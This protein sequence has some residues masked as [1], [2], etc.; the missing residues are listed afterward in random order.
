MTAQAPNGRVLSDWPF[1]LESNCLASRRV[2]DP[3]H[4]GVLWCYQQGTSM[5]SPHVTGVAALII[6][7]FGPMPPGTVV[8]YI[9]QTADPQ[10]CPSAA[11]QAAL[12]ASFPS[13]DTGGPQVCQG[14]S[15][16][17]SWYGDGQVNALSAVTHS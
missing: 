1:A 8:A 12:S 13:L 17:N 2:F 9:K 11:E 6:S 15:G 4:P 16:H 10:P 5:A 3:G 7:Q 14:G